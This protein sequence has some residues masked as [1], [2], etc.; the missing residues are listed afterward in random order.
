MSSVF[1]GAAALAM[2]LTST[3]IISKNKTRIQGSTCIPNSV[4]TSLNTY[5]VCTRE[6][7]ACNALENIYMQDMGWSERTC[8]EAKASRTMLIPTLLSAAVVIAVWIAQIVVSRNRDT[9]VADM[10]V[11][12][13]QQE[14]KWE[15]ST[16]YEPV[17]P[18][19]QEK[20]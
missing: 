19:T 17:R 16:A 7:A 3:I 18:G 6:L 9:A 1:F 12:R 8:K 10:R 4:Y 2:S 15:K 13:L 14:G 5:Y 20:A 11:E